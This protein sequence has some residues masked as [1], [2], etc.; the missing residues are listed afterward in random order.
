M[1]S[2]E[3]YKTRSGAARWLVRYD[4]YTNGNRLQK[5][6]SFDTSKAAKDFAA[7]TETAILTGRYSDAKGLTVGQYLTTWLGTYTTALRPNSLRGYQSAINKQLMP[8]LGGERLEVLTTA[9]IQKAY[10]DIL[11][12]EYAPAK[13]ESHGDVRVLVKPAKKYTPKTLCNVHAV[14]RTALEQARRE[15][16]IYRNPAD[17]VKLPAAKPFE[18]TIPEPEQLQA[19][20]TELRGAECYLA[21]LACA[22]LACRRGESLGLYWSDIDFAASTVEI[23]RALI[24]NNLTNHVEIGELKTKNSRRTLPLP[25][26]LRDALLKAKQ[27]KTQAAL[28]AGAHIVDSPFVFTNAAGKPFRPDS[29]SQ[30]FKRAAVKVGLPDM[31]LHDLRHTGITYMLIDGADAKTVSGFVGHATAQ[32]TLNQYAHV[33]EQAKKKA[34]A[35][36]ERKVLLPEN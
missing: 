6:R 10:N 23:R 32:F 8:R 33:M 21:I 1:A 13:Y 7:T 34:G 11:N 30:A 20:L 24:I 25:T 35:L 26:A 19:L 31:R 15:G 17:D 5:A 3:K 29:I 28:D 2:I 14:L 9:K 22:L 12:T 27:E 16:L 4:T 36:L 18:Y